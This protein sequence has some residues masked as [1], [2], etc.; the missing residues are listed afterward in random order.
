MKA[1]VAEHEPVVGIEHRYRLG[2]GIDGRCQLLLAVRHT[3][4]FRNVLHDGDEQCLAAM[5]QLCH[6]SRGG[7]RCTVLA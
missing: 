3:S 1:L 2:H 5:L 7:K 6:R 4:M